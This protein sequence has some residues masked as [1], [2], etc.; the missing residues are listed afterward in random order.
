MQAIQGV[1]REAASPRA[2]RPAAAPRPIGDVDRVLTI[3]SGKHDPA[4]RAKAGALLGRRAHRS[5]LS[6]SSALNTISALVP[7]AA[8]SSSLTT[9]FAT[10]TR[11]SCTYWPTIDSCH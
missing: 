11:R 5:S 4:R 7:I 3:G 8:P 10:Y 1:L 2:G 6:R 9:E